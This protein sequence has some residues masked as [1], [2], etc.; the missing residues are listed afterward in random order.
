MEKRKA[1]EISTVNTSSC[2]LYCGCTQKPT[3]PN[4]I[5]FLTLFLEEKTSSQSKQKFEFIY[6]FG[7]LFD[8]LEYLRIQELH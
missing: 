8:C 1:L 4:G 2:S 3:Y 5:G 7:A 6:I